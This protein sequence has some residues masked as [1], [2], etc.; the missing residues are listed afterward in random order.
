MLHLQFEKAE[1]FENDL[2]THGMLPLGESNALTEIHSALNDHC[3]KHS[4][5]H[6]I[7][8]IGIGKLPGEQ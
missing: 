7:K 5:D 8:A 2:N 4:H 6:G 1:I 3:S